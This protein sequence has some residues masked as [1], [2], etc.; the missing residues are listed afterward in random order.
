MREE[1]RGKKFGPMTATGK[2]GPPNAG[3]DD[4]DS[5]RGDGAGWATG[6]E[7]AKNRSAAP[8]GLV[9]FL[10]ANPHLKMRAIV[11]RAAGVRGM[12]RRFA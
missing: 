1:T 10:G 4:R 6:C 9:A 3:L 2:C 7:L 8:V 5:F 12:E 11:N